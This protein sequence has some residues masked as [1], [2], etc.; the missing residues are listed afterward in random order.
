VIGL[1]AY[2]TMLV[3]S[4]ALHHDLACHA[5]SPTHCEACV[6]NPLAPPAEPGFTLEA[7]LVIAGDV[8][9]PLA[10]STFAAPRPTASGRAPPA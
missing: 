5:K 6:A 7:A 10:A 2:A 4:P 1:A 9:G 3:V 8:E